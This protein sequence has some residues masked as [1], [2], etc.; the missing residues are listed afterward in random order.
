MLLSPCAAGDLE[1]ENFFFLVLLASTH[2]FYAIYITRQLITAAQQFKSE[3][4][5][6]PLIGYV[7]SRACL[8]II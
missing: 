2:I 6:K 3:S 4:S 1:E 8:N 5:L 7:T